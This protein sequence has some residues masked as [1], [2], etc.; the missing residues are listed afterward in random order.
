MKA[1][2]LLVV[3]FLSAQVSQAA[4][5]IDCRKLWDLERELGCFAYYP[6]PGAPQQTPEKK[7]FVMESQFG[8]T[9]CKASNAIESAKKDLKKECDG[10]LKERKEDLAGKYRTGTCNAKC[11]SCGQG[12]ERCMT[13]GLVHY[14][15]Q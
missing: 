12:L 1:F 11:D 5:Q 15:D 9:P 2:G 13:T 3:L 6:S 4:P 10:W 7:E 14:S 8:P